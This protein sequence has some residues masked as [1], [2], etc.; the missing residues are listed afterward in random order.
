MEKTKLNK[1]KQWIEIICDDIKRVLTFNYINNEVQGL[2]DKNPDIQIGTTFYWWL[3]NIYI[4]SIAIGIR[5]QI[6]K[7]S[8][9]ISLRR[10]LEDIK[11]NPEIISRERFVASWNNKGWAKGSFDKLAGEGTQINTKI[12]ENDLKIIEEKVGKIKGLANKKIAHR[13][14]NDF[15]DL[16]TYKE[17]DECCDYLK[18][19][20]EKYFFLLHGIGLTIILPPLY[21]WKKIFRIPWIKQSTGKGI[22]P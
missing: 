22:H 5:R 1:Y 19:I 16:P 15:Q 4:E 10:L 14:K 7:R 17:I 21:D 9:S 18:E 20:V 12:I 13:D 11:N 2:I 8:D 6:D 3:D